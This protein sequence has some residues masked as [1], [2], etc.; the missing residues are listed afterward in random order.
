MARYAQVHAQYRYVANVIEWDGNPETWPPPEGYEMI[1]DTEGK[2]GP[3]YTYEGGTFVP[4]PGGNVPP[5]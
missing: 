4:P 5:E 3:G 2:A 1:E